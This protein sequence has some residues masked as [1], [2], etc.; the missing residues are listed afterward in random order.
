MDLLFD[1]KP[2]ITKFAGLFAVD[3]LYSRNLEEPEEKKGMLPF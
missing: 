2:E 1:A 3:D